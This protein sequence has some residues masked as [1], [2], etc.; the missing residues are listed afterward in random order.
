MSDQK[1]Y[2]CHKCHFGFTSKKRLKNHLNKPIP[3]VDFKCEY[4]EKELWSKT[5]YYR[6]RA[7]CKQKNNAQP[8]INNNVNENIGNTNNATQINDIKNNIVMMHPLG[9]MHHYMNKTEVISPVKGIVLELLRQQKY[10]MAYQKL[11]EQIHGN[12]ALPEHHNVYV[13]RTGKNEICIFNG[14][15]FKTELLDIMMPDMFRTLK[16]EMKWIVRTSDLDEKEKDQLLWDVQANW[17]NVNEYNDENMERIMYNNKPVVQKTVRNNEVY[18]N[19]EYIAKL[20]DCKPE[21][22]VFKNE[23]ITLP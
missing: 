20:N 10:E 18:T 22:V 11:F 16:G 5:N 17:M 23:R 14:R 19:L 4:C 7:K 15:Y 2:K 21:E 12:P 9:L 13:P 1:K 8:H 3:C 6:H